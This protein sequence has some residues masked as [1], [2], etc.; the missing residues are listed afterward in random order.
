MNAHTTHESRALEARRRALRAARS[1]T[2]SVLAL[3]VNACAFSVAPV[4]LTIVD[5]PVQSE[6][7]VVEAA[8]ADSGPDVAIT[9]DVPVTEDVV[10]D[11]ATETDAGG[12]AGENCTPLQSQPEAYTECCRRNG[13]NF[14]LGCAAWGPFMPPEMGA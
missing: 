6:A 1:V 2:L 10:A 4:D 12:D 13:W 8:V 7:S 5:A 11:A 3:A 14:E 9:E